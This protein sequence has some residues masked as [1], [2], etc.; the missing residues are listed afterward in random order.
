MSGD[1]VELIEFASFLVWIFYG[2]AMVA[3][4]VLRKTK[5][6]VLRPYKVKDY[7]LI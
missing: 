1:V 6:N 7:I 4:L 5:K 3:L 2:L